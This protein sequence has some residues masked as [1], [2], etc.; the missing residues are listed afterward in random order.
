MKGIFLG[1]DTSGRTTGLA[2]VNDK[3]VVW[4]KRTA[5]DVSHNER[6]LPLIGTAFLESG[7]KLDEVT[8]ICLT[9][10]PGMFTSLRVGL[11]VAKGLALPRGILVKGVNTLQA[12]S[13]TAER[14]RG[15]PLVLALIDARKGEFYAGLYQGRETV[16]APKVTSP[17][18]L[19]GLLGEIDFSGKGLVLAGDGAEMA[20]PVLKRAGYPIDKTGIT[21]PSPLAVIHLGVDLFA[22]EGGDDLTNLEPIYLRRTDAELKREQLRQNNS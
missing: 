21:Y 20:E 17:E 2:L 18:G 7:L 15:N 10:G 16:I 3:M 6:L 11:S 14:E 9:I 8:G 4:E 19:T 12:L 22:R 13:F 1:L 5:A